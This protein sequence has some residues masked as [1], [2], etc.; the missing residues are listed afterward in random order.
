MRFFHKRSRHLSLCCPVV[1][2]SACTERT[3]IYV[4]SPL[5]LAQISVSRPLCERAQVQMSHNMYSL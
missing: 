5:V 2:M 3:I 1:S 4:Y